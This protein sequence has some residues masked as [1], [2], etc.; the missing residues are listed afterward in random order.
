MDVFQVPID[1]DPV[2]VTPVKGPDGNFYIPQAAIDS[3]HKHGVGT[4]RTSCYANRKGSQV[5]Q[6]S[7]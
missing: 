1:W 5:T 6:L 7:T 3:V 2:D 4:K